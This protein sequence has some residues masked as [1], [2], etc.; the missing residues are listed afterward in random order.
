MRG[1]AGVDDVVGMQLPGFIDTLELGGV[2]AGVGSGVDSSADDGV[3]NVGR[4][5]WHDAERVAVLP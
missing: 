5:G 2:T 3:G 4:I 1:Q